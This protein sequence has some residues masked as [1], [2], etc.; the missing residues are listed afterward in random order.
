MS[1]QMRRLLDRYDV[2]SEQMLLVAIRKEYEQETGEK[3][4]EAEIMVILDR[5][6]E[7]EYQRIAGGAYDEE[8]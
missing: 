5:M 3:Y 2:M 1:E 7:A 6:L 4:S 8:V